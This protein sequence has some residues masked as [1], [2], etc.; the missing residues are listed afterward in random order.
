MAVVAL[1]AVLF[2]QLVFHGAFSVV[3]TTEIPSKEKY[4]ALFSLVAEAFLSF[5]V[6]HVMAFDHTRGVEEEFGKSYKVMS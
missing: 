5:I 6:L 3:N 2:S 1:I 4:N